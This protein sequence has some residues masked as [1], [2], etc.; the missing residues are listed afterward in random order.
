MD[1]VAIQ[2]LR[3]I[4]PSVSKVARMLEGL[5]AGSDSVVFNS[6]R[7]SVS[8]LRAINKSAQAFR[9]SFYGGPPG[10]VAWRKGSILNMLEDRLLYLAAYIGPG[11]VLRRCPAAKSILSRHGLE[12][13]F[14]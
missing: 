14:V 8:D 10:K 5:D 11:N 6:Q 2:T 13:W 1:M 4:G 3:S 9:V 12:E 7:W